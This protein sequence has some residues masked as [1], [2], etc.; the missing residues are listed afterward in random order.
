M[1]AKHFKLIATA[2]KR[3]RPEKGTKKYAQWVYDTSEVALELKRNFIEFD[4][5]AFYALCS[6]EK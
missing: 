3:S 6:E 2:L 5:E 1:K 4:D